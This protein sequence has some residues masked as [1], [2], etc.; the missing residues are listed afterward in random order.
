MS[1][2]ALYQ[3]WFY[4]FALRLHSKSRGV[5]EMSGIDMCVSLFKYERLIGCM[6][7]HRMHLMRL[8][9]HCS[10]FLTTIY[11]GPTSVSFALV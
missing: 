3:V 7:C 8:E 1:I 11:I 10:N 4:Y 9:F 5:G 6:P 2:M